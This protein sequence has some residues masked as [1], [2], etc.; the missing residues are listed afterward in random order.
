MSTVTPASAGRPT[1]WVIACLLVALLPQLAS[2]PVHLAALTLVAPAWRT[3]A[4]WRHWKPLH[5]LVRLAATII[6][7]VVLF[8]TYGNPL[9]RRTAV[10]LLAL[11]LSLKLLETFKVRDARL[12]ASLALFLAATQFLF[13][14]GLVMVV[15]AAAVMAAALVTFALLARA[16][17]FFGTGQPA[18]AGPGMATEVRY[19]LRLMVIALPAALA[20]FMFFPRW[21]SPL[22]GVPEESL[23]ARTGLSGEMTPGSIQNLFMDDTPAF[24]VEFTSP[25]PPQ[26]ALYWRGPVFW[27]F[28]GRSWEGSYYGRNIAARE[29]PTVGNAESHYTVLMEPTEQHWMFALDYP[30]VTPPDSRV[31]LDFQLLSRK[32][33]TRLR[34]YEMMSDSDFIDSPELSA[35]LRDQ[36][37]RLPDGFNPRT[38]ELMAEWKAEAATDAE[39][40]RRALAHFNAEPFRYTLNPALLTRHSVDEFLFDTREG[41]CEHYASAFTVMMRMLGIPAR[42]VTGYQ[43]GWYNE[44]GDYVLVRQSDAH[45]WSEVWLPGT[46]WTRVDPTAAVAPSR[47]EQGAMDA[48][49]G[50]RHALDFAWVRELRNGVDWL[51]RNWNDWVIA[52]DAARQSRLLSAFGIEQLGPRALVALLTLGLLL[53]S[54]FIVPWL[55]RRSTGRRRDPLG[56]AWARFLRRLDKVGVE[57]RPSMGP[58]EVGAAAAATLPD[59]AGEIDA[60]T[61]QY[62]RLRYAADGG[63]LDAF[64]AGVRGF[65]VN[66][67]RKSG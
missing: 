40:V 38:R 45:A 56:R 36:A 44:F 28:D 20:L 10:S 7:M 14:Q 50:R 19:S 32:P 42:V 13:S 55:L 57:I 8:S 48:L 67:Q 35:T 53:A 12:V 54:A 33:I 16:Q 59:Q 34:Q 3:L 18:P 30:A 64:T 24:R 15:Y 23:D 9:G 29:K 39:L 17:A 5:P 22:W 43:G 1:Y 65:R 26:Q 31:T 4:E 52:F 2:M 47:V 11:M 21:S 60:I 41:F 51:G 46:G 58:R 6:A 62:R 25:V 37:L 27:N 66:P 61:G 63:R 49:E